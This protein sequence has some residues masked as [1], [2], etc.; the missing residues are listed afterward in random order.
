MKSLANKASPASSL[1]TWEMQQDPYVYP[2][3]H[4]FGNRG[5]LESARLVLLMKNLNPRERL[6]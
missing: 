5:V 2:N 4:Y 3:F 1:I 6:R